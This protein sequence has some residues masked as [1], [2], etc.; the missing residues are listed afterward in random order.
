MTLIEL[1]LKNINNLLDDPTTLDSDRFYLMKLYEELLNPENSV[2]SIPVNLC[3]P[4][5]GC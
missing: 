2:H 3:Q 5:A 4:E 1:A